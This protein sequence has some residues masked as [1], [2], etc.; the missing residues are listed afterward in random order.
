[1]KLDAWL[2]VIL[3]KRP[4]QM[5]EAEVCWAGFAF[6]WDLSGALHQ[7]G[8][9][10]ISSQFPDCLSP[11]VLGQ[12]PQRAPCGLFLSSL[13]V[14]SGSSRLQSCDRRGLPPARE[15]CKGQG[16]EAQVPLPAPVLSA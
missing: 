10:I 12:R 3:G 7:R 16:P 5:K 8:S 1:M 11:P 13:G 6:P 4:N 15:G 9:C 14:V 2:A